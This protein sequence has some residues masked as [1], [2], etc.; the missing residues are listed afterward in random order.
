MFYNNLE[1]LVQ[2]EVLKNM[3]FIFS[4]VVSVSPSQTLVGSHKLYTALISLVRMKIPQLTYTLL[5][6]T[7]LIGYPSQGVFAL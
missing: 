4:T 7:N 3:I 5:K 2:G 6:V 1:E